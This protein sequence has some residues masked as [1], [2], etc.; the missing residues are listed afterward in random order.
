MARLSNPPVYFTLAQVRFNRLLK[1]DDF[2][3]DIQEKLRQASFPDFTTQTALALEI[4]FQS[5]PTPSPMPV[6]VKRYQFGDTAR[7]HA[8]ILDQDSL[9]LQSTEYG[10]F[11]QFSENFMRGLE[12]LHECVRLDYIERIGLRYLDR[13]IPQEG[14]DLYTYLAPEIAGLTRKLPGTPVHAFSESENIV[15]DM[16][17][18]SRVIIQSSPL[19]FPPDIVPGGMKVNSRLAKYEG[20]HAILDN[21]GIFESRFAFASEVVRAQLNDIHNV[22]G[23][24]FRAAGSEHAFKVW[25][26]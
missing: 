22:I 13:V 21:D 6:P 25:S 8:F 10:D 24:A 2:L 12:I 1:L 3:P 15:K 20:P 9:T 23:A 17:L 16:K 26:S 5:G 11:P 19:A 7:T 18:L 14:E 4:N